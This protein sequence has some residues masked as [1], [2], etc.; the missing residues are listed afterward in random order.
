M[1]HEQKIS[2]LVWFLKGHVTVKIEI[3]MQNF[4]FCIS[5]ILKYSQIENSF[6]KL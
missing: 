1:F 3:M 6:F 2:I 4:L 5:E